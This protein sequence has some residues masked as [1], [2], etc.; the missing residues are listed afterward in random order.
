[1]LDAPPLRVATYWALRY[2]RSWRS[3]LLPSLL[4]P[5]LYMVIMGK[6]LGGIID[7]GDRAGETGNDYLAFVA[8]AVVAVA[9]MLSA[10]AEATSQVFRAVNHTHTYAAMQAT[11]LDVRDV[12]HGHLL[13]MAARITLVSV[14]LT[15]LVVALGAAQSWTVIALV[16][17]GPLTGM[18]VASG[19]TAW[20]A[21][22]H[23]QAN[24]LAWQRFGAT[25]MLLFGGTFYPV[26]ELPLVLR[27]FAELTPVWHGAELARAAATGHA[28]ARDVVGHVAYL[29]LLIVVGSALATRSVAHRLEAP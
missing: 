22:Q 23:K 20:S 6:V 7:R 14:V 10:S 24:M 19:L 9:A 3:S 18:A 28:P 13:W 5:C 21:R 29:V 16:A 17:V 1:M 11:S 2:R 12:V 25:P 4:G 27:R 15:T 8:P 26:S